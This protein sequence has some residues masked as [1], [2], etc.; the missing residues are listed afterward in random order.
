[1]SI[2][3]LCELTLESRDHRRL[4]SFY[5]RVLE[6]PVMS[7]ED[8]R[9]WLRCGSRARL[10]LWSPGEK[11][12]GDRG[13]RHVHFAFSVT[14]G[15]LQALTERLEELGVGHRGPV[16]HDGGD[17]SLYFEDPE[18]NLVEVWDYFEDGDGR[19]EGVAG[20]AP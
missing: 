14:R 7:E 3:G 16:D 4:A 11:E 18:G 12:F 20:L 2:R 5:A 17:R 9:V 19:V 8:D 13:G 15:G 10:G 1:M 6:L